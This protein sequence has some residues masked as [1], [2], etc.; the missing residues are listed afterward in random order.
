AGL[1]AYDTQRLKS[2]YVQMA[3]MGASGQQLSASAIGGALSLYLN[4]LNMFMFLLQF[5]GA[6]RE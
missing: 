5:M 4:F 6:A 3:G 2:E 1:T